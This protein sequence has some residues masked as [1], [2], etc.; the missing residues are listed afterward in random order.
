[1]SPRSDPFDAFAGALL[2][3]ARPVPDGL[4]PGAGGASEPSAAAADEMA[5]RFAIYR[6]T[7]IAGLV[8]VLADGFPAVQALVGTPFFRA[9]AAEFVRSRPPRSPALVEYGGEFPAFLADF[10]PAAGLAYLRDVAALEWART[11]AYN[12]RDLAP[13][14]I[15]LLARLPAEGLARL[16]LQTHPSALLLRS[17]HPFVSLWAESTGREPRTRL[18][19]GKAENAL[20]LRE[21]EA[22]TVRRLPPATAAFLQAVFSGGT[23][24][25]AALAADGIDLPAEI[26]AM[27]AAGLVVAILPDEALRHDLEQE[28]S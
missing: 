22:V 2:D 1:M 11:L 17:R 4:S 12:A 3:P 14:G 26:A 28:G 25:D 20:I 8:D 23:L 27:F 24:G 18:D 9:A 10:P 19:L 6:N 7:F 5:R 21:G 15:D 16:R 13:A